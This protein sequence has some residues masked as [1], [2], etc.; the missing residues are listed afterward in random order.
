MTVNVRVYSPAQM[1][2]LDS[3]KVFPKSGGMTKSLLL[4]LGIAWLAI[5]G[6]AACDLCAVYSA[7]NANGLKPGW[8]VSVSEQYTYFATLQEDGKQVGNPVGQRLDSSI[9]QVVLG[10]QFNERAGVQVN[11]P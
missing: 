1:W 4:H 10:Y 6:A 7:A 9:T 2:S 11:V 5:A 8:Q 3:R